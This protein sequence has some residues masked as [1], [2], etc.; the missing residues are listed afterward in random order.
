MTTSPDLSPRIFELR[1][2]GRLDP[3]WTA[4]FPEMTLAP[5]ADG[6]TVL[7]G[8]LPDQ[9]ALHGLLAR[10]RD[11]GMSLQSVVQIDDD[12]SVMRAAVYRRFG[13]PDVVTIDDLP[14]PTPGAGELLI[15]VRATTV[16][17]ADHRT[18]ARDI[19]RGLALPSAL[20]VGLLRPRRPVLGMDAAGTVVAVGAGVT[21]FAP[22]D[23][24]VAMLGSSFGGHAEFA[25]VRA[26][27]AAIAP[28]PESLSFTDAAAL[29]FGGVTAQAYLR[30]AGIGP[31]TRVLVNG[32]SGAVG[33]AMVQLARAA[34]AEV[35]GVTSATNGALVTSLGAHRV[36]DYA[37]E[38]FAADGSV[39]DVVADCVGNAPV[40][41]VHG[42]VAPGG[43][44]LLVVADLPALLTAAQR[45]RRHG[46]RVVTGPG[47]YRD[48]D[49]EHVLRL[50]A[51][52]AIRPVIE[53]E[54]PLDQ[55]VE[56]HRLVDGN[57]KRGSVVV[58]IP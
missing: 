4:S 47:A 34:G 31:G 25:L 5:A 50:A 20:V 48:D 52:G 29:V 42:I 2:A 55:I 54:F 57:R 32:A 1:V 21:R 51:D 27:G 39:Y 11:A 44:V 7:R 58:T 38:D 14:R 35:T 28:Q 19:P 16:S 33:T 3:R 45:A 26:S 23:D 24:V 43:S 40:D 37:T 15:R 8:A 13:G 56:A 41:R 36:I 46:I 6:T 49:L 30:Q 9:A 53:R 12:R 22:G 17:A 18:R 10:V